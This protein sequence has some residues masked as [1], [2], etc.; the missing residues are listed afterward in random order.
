MNPAMP[1]SELIVSNALR[2]TPP[3][4]IAVSALAPDLTKCWTNIAAMTRPLRVSEWR[5]EFSGE[6]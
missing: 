2:S 1:P 4:F 5:C 6:N 3:E